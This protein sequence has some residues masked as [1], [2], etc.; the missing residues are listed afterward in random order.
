MK[1]NER[2]LFR[3]LML[4]FLLINLMVITACK[5]Q[6]TGKTPEL[7][8]EQEQSTVPLAS[9]KKPDLFVILLDA[10]RADGINREIKGQ[11]VMPNL[12]RFASENTSFTYA[13]SSSSSTPTS[14]SA[15]F[16]SLPVPVFQGNFLKGIPRDVPV[17]ADTLSQGGY[18]TLGYS[19]NPN[20]SS[21][22]GHDRGFERFVQAFSDSTLATGQKIN[23]DHPARIV[24]PDVLLDKVLEDLNPPPADP[25]FVYIHLLQPHAP[26]SPPSPHS[27]MF[28][29]ADQPQVEL[30]LS[31][32]IDMDRKG[33]LKPSWF[34]ALRSH[35]DGHCHWVD[36]VVGDFLRN[37]QSHP[38]FS[39][40]GI[41]I[42]S[43][44]GEGF[45]EHRK[46]LHNTTV[47][48]EMIRIPLI[49]KLPRTSVASNQIKIPVDLID[50]APTLCRLAGI[51][52]P[53]L[54]QGID[55]L[56]AGDP[57]SWLQRPL[58]SVAVSRKYTSL[59]IG[60][61]KI[62][63]LER[64][65]KLHSAI[66]DC[67]ADP[68]ERQDLAK[69]KPDIYQALNSHLNNE[70][71]R[72][73][74]LDIKPALPRSLSGEKLEILRSLGYVDISSPSKQTQEPDN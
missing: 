5:S 58:L 37:L 56:A 36:E 49:I 73:K 67:W 35:Y 70:L 52:P 2:F 10:L 20:C 11:L 66:F 48:E 24:N 3:I 15:L 27:E 74:N 45:G 57:E 51:E 50:V 8:E 43:D 14:I 72:Y 46:I 25:V 42:L 54:F 31:T 64:K 32:L 1:N 60:Q 13:Q 63:R 7:L 12:Y 17:L 59:R 47:F 6:E 55:I 69:K 26:Y 4:V 44:H 16:S 65:N 30:D 9:S 33:K 53:E 29:I 38:R 22:L 28:V 23:E 71:L 39:R 62:I 21:N 61:Y 34:N 40:A 41:I 18:L 19:A 68:G